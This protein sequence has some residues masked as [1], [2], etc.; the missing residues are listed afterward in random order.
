MN[1][2][3]PMN[4]GRDIVVVG[5]SAG[6]VEAL[7]NLAALLP[8]DLPAAL[9]VVLHMPEHGRSAL[10]GILARAGRLPAAQAVDGEP[11]E[12]GRVYV[13]PPGEHLELR[14]GGVHLGRGPRENGYRPAIDRLFVTAAR[15]YGPRVTGVILSGALDDGTL[16]LME[17]WRAG[18]APLVQDPSEALYPAMPESA[19]GYVDAAAVLSLEEIGRQIDALA[20][21]PFPEHEEEPVMAEQAPNPESAEHA[22]PGRL[23]GLTCPECNGA[24]WEADEEGLLRYRCRVGHAYSAESLASEQGAALEAALWAALRALEE[25]V[26]LSL[27]LSRRFAAGNHERAAS[28][29]ERQ[30]DEARGQAAI[31]RRALDLVSAGAEIA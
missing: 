28:R 4:S 17:V 5:A 20:R 6:G 18:G 30:A 11:V 24:L 15:S 16:G 31:L 27:R 9:F 23:S 19:S 2:R 13:A 14:R 26:A 29:Y 8:G 10:P 25:R 1:D 22:Q 3:G 7:K 12:H 21:E